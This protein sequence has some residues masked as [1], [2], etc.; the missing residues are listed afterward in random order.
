MSEETSHQPSVKSNQTS[1]DATGNPTR[2]TENASKTAENQEKEEEGA[3]DTSKVLVDSSEESPDN[4]ENHEKTEKAGET[5]VVSGEKATRPKS[6]LNIVKLR[7][8]VEKKTPETEEDI[9]DFLYTPGTKSHDA[10]KI[11]VFEGISDSATIVERTGLAKKTA[12]MIRS[13]IFKAAEK[14]R[15]EQK[16][17]SSIVDKQDKQTSKTRLDT[18]DNPNQQSKIHTLQKGKQ[19]KSSVQPVSSSLVSS[20]V[21][22]PLAPLPLLRVP[23]PLLR[24]S[25]L[26]MKGLS[27]TPTSSQLASRCQKSNSQN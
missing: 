1:V 20:P 7:E 13:A 5:S 12:S 2:P 21:S 14:L 10:A 22:S 6:R 27:C 25:P 4:G 3:L 11:I 19:G 8:A 17:K 18:P 23:L 16:Q 26:R 24:E 9:P 15:E